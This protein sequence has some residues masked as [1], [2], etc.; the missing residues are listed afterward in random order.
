MKP[1]DNTWALRGL[2]RV[3]ACS[4]PAAPK[5]E[6]IQDPLPEYIS[7]TIKEQAT[8]DPRTRGRSTCLVLTD[9]VG[10][11][12]TW[13]SVASSPLVLSVWVWEWQPEARPASSGG[14]FSPSSQAAA[15]A[16][17]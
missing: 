17:G 9:S 5:I 7:V 10:Q 2:Y 6:T 8:Q 16:V 3:G 1:G 12:S 4:H 15:D 11:Q 13:H 14:S